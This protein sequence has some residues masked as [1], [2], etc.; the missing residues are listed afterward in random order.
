[1]SPISTSSV[2]SS[3][4]LAGHINDIGEAF[5]LATRL[6]LDPIAEASGIKTGAPLRLVS[7]PLKMSGTPPTVESAPP[8]LGKHSEEIRAWLQKGG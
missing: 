6:G 5:E 8:R 2:R 4:V 3:I 1:M 7:S